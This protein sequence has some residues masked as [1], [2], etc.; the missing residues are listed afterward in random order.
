MLEQTRISVKFY[1][2]CNIHISIIWHFANISVWRWIP[3][4]LK[5]NVHL[6]WNFICNP[7]V[8]NVF[9]TW[10]SVNT[11]FNQQYQIQKISIMVYLELP[12]PAPGDKPV[13]CMF[14]VILKFWVRLFFHCRRVKEDCICNKVRVSKRMKICNGH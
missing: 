2:K 5:M 8:C 7:T 4:H 10:R 9:N 14:H 11:F 12:I 3:L 13:I 6:L 1:H